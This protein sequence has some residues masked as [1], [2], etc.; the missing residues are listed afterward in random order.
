MNLELSIN[1]FQQQTIQNEPPPIFSVR[2]SNNAHIYHY[3]SKP[4]FS[5][6]FCIRKKLHIES[7]IFICGSITLQFSLHEN[8]IAELICERLI[9]FSMQHAI[10]VCIIFMTKKCNYTSFCVS[11]YSQII[12]L[13]FLLFLYMKRVFFVH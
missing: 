13:Q 3:A 7:R 1:S 4:I 9:N 12:W 6:Y 5:S 8:K 11:A 2:T 10:Y